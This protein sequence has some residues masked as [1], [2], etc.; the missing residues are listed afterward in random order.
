MIGGPVEK[1]LFG[2]AVA[3]FLIAIAGYRP[4]RR[5]GNLTPIQLISAAGAWAL[6]LA[7][8]SAL[9]VAIYTGSVI[10]VCA[11]AATIA[12]ALITFL[13]DEVTSV[14]GDEPP[15]AVKLVVAD[16]RR[17]LGGAK[18][19]GME[20]LDAVVVAGRCPGI[21]VTVMRQGRVVV[22]IR[23]DVVRWLERHQHGGAGPAVIASFVRFTVLHELGHILNGD[24]R[25][26]RF[27]RSVLVAHL[28]WVVAAIAAAASFAAD[29]DS[30]PLAVAGSIVLI[31][32]V[33]SL[34]A[35][36]FIAERERWADWR[37]MQTLAPADATRLLE[38]R[39]RRRPMA[40][41][42]ELEKLMIDL[43]AQVP[44]RRGWRLLAR[45]IRLVWPEGDDVHRRAEMAAGD[46]AGGDPRPVHWAA[47]LGM[48]CGLLAMSL[49]L[50]AL[51]ALGP[52]IGW[53][54]DV[55]LGVM[56]A[57]MAWSSGPAATFCQILIDPARMSVHAVKRLRLRVLVAVVFY[58]AFAA[59]AVVLHQ[60]HMRFVST[61]SVAFFAVMLF[62]AAMM[63]A[64]CSWVAAV[65][66]G[67]HG[68]GELPD[69]PRSARVRSQPL[70]AV[71]VLVL[72][73]LSFLLSHWLRLGTFTSWHWLALAFA[74]F[75]AYV[76]STMMARS[77]NQLLHTIA[78]VALLDTPS[79]VYGFRVFWRDVYID[80]SRMTLPRAAATAIAVH[81]AGLLFFA[82]G[83]SVFMY[84]LR[85]V[86]TAQATLIVTMGGGVAVIGLALVI[87]DRYAPYSD[88]SVS[89]LDRSWLEIFEKLLAAARLA[90]PPAADELSAALSQWL[91]DRR[92]PDAV[93]PDPRSL[94]MLAP[95]LS[96]VRLAKETG[97]TAVLETWRSRIEQSL[98]PLIANDAVAA[99]PGQPPSMHW[100]TAAAAIVDE[101]GLRDAFPFERIL[102][103]IETM[104]DERLEA[105]TDNLLTDVV[106]AS[107]LLRRHRRTAPDLQRLRRF[108]DSSSL[109]SRPL[110]RQ[111][112]A[113]L[114]ELAEL[115]ADSELQERL[116]TI[117]R[118][119]SW[120]VLQ[121]NPRK[122]VLLLLDCYLAA[123]R[124][125]DIDPREEAAASTIGEI[126]GAVSRE[127]LA[128]VAS[129]GGAELA[130]H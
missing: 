68:G 57:A 125:G 48:Q 11:V 22:R 17:L 81:S 110:L 39:G 72:L 25:T 49:S 118:S 61:I 109:V 28:V 124:L 52:W 66:G 30:A 19:L 6:V 46:R 69:T 31:G 98:R 63:T 117:V 38:R 130:Q 113:E 84:L 54:Y 15:A 94:W 24:H 26:F 9:A 101:A 115:T 103:R 62:A 59:S 97:E 128:V 78:P 83:V 91:R 92:F 27:V 50:A 96:V 8:A 121:L 56:L 77:T 12:I 7:N 122:D 129:R 3:A 74:S 116:G 112:L 126:A 106:V 45:C 89:L 95:L 34:V 23:G 102:D 107:R 90:N 75:M 36:R 44:P 76:A 104:L 87:P 33:Q 1:A 37:A 119:R 18:R 2:V 20:S 108:A 127:L 86:L 70:V 79:P 40:N 73:P 85:T 64:L 58:L 42:T 51:F 14:S 93:L 47:L 29:G 114:C 105:G 4:E 43:K 35:R 5:P 21:G 88:P 53:R 55:A 67:R 123:A 10:L 65:M 120:E 32:T 111:S 60:F 71:L 100:T 80:L 41:P 99:A 13:R 82:V 16:L